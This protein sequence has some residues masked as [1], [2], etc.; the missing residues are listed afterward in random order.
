MLQLF[1]CVS[2]A[3]APGD[4]GGY[5]PYR[6]SKLTRL[7]QPSLG[8]NAK[9]TIICTVTGALLSSD[10][11]HNTLKFANRAKRMKNHAAINEVSN[12]KT[13]LKKYVEE[14]AEL[15]EE[16]ARAKVGERTRCF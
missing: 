4:R 2:V 13:L 9:I 3:I 7:L 5:I 14:I 15:R 12:E 6:D 10:E 16:L 1:G 11:T 8:G